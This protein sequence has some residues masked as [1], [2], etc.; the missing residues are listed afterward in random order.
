MTFVT[1]PTDNL[2]FCHPVLL[3]FFLQLSSSGT[4][5][6]EALLLAWGLLNPRT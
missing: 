2:L 6:V 3:F 4:P 1:I 5:N